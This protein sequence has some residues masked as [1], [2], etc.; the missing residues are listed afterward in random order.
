MLKNIFR[1]IIYTFVILI[2][3]STVVFAQNISSTDLKAALEEEFRWIEMEVFTASKKKQRISEAPA[4]ISAVSK[5]EIENMGAETLIDVLHYLPGIET[6]MGR[7]GDYRVSIRGVRQHGTI[8]VLLNGHRLNLFYNGS[9]LYDFPLD[10]VERIEVIRGPG[11]ALYGTN[12]VVGVINIFLDNHSKTVKGLFGNNNSLKAAVNHNDTINEITYTINGI[13]AQSDGANAGQEDDR[14]SDEGNSWSLAYQDKK[15]QTN[16]WNKDSVI[17]LGIH[18]DNFEFLL[19]GLEQNRG[20][21]IGPLFDATR[22]SNY[23]TR[24]LL[25]DFSY[26]IKLNESFIITPKLYGDLVF[27]NNLAQEAPPGYQNIANETFADGKFTKITYQANT[28]GTEIQANFMFSDAL[29]L[30]T[31]VQYEILQMPDYTLERNYKIIG[32]EYKG[33][34]AEYD[35]ISL[36]QKGK[37]RN[38]FAYF[39]QGSYKLKKAEFT[40]GFRY[41]Q[42]SDFGNTLNPRIACVYKPFDLL[43][44]KIMHGQAFRAPTFEELYDFSNIGTDGLRGNTGL[45]AQKI[46]TTELS[47][48]MSFSKL[49]FKST[50]FIS[51]QDNIIREYDPNG[52]GSTGQYQNIGNTKSIGTEFEAKYIFNKYFNFFFNASWFE[53]KFTWDTTLAGLGNYEQNLTEDKKI[54]NTIPR[55]RMNAGINLLYKKLKGFI[56]INWGE[57]SSNNFINALDQLSEHKSE[58]PAYLQLDIILTY[59]LQPNTSLKL[60]ING[61][62]TKKSDPNNLSKYHLLGKNGMVQPE[63]SYTLSVEHKF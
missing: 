56:G 57:K 44:L 19:M 30:I 7:D 62:G 27:L 13:Y 12:G 10:F 61:L 41:D 45:E 32:D 6:S 48:E 17:N 25:S 59:Q 3:S 51:G 52:S 24:Q 31:G 38:V 8:L 22:G 2:F 33:T 21:W 63:T 39:L 34:F 53:T 15:A 28:I 54:I 35:G 58:I 29:D 4:I 16:R 47:G 18:N 43:T 37:S 55:L 11:S 60:T 20:S 40:A 23:R 50:V 9:V 36:G 14:S 1:S 49:K 26:K 5:K 42:Y 46:N